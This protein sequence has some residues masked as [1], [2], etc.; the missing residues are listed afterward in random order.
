MFSCK[1]EAGLL[2]Q[3]FLI[4]FSRCVLHR[5]QS[6]RLFCSLVS[7][8]FS[9]LCFISSYFLSLLC[10]LG[11]LFRCC[12]VVPLHPPTVYP[13]LPCPRHPPRRADW[14]PRGQVESLSALSHLLS[15]LLVL[16]AIFFGTAFPPFPL[17]PRFPVFLHAVRIGN[18]II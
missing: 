16:F 5:T 3:R 12:S 6:N 18:P 11:F 17:C 14:K 2:V 8:G 9:F 1:C 7:S 4:F 10:F 15:I 13:S